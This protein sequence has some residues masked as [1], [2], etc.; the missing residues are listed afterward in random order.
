IEDVEPSMSFEKNLFKTG[1]AVAVTFRNVPTNT[2]AWVG[3]YKRGTVYPKDKSVKYFYTDGKDDNSRPGNGVGLIEGLPAGEY[4]MVL[5]GDGNYGKVLSPHIAFEVSTRAD[6]IPLTLDKNNYTVG[7]EIKVTYSAG[8]V[9]KADWIGIY[10]VDKEVGAA[11]GGQPSNV[12]KTIPTQSKAATLS[13]RDAKKMPAGTYYAVYLLDGAYE[14]ASQRVFF[15]IGEN[16][17]LQTTKLEYA[18]GEFVDFNV[19]GLEF[20][21]SWVVIEDEAS[22]KEV[23]RRYMDFR[24]SN[25]TFFKKFPIGKY[26]ATLQLPDNRIAAQSAPFTVTKGTGI[27]E[28]SVV[29]EIYPNPVK[30]TFSLPINGCQMLIAYTLD[31]K[32]VACVQ[33]QGKV[34]SLASLAS[35]HYFLKAKTKDAVYNYRIVKE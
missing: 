35:G 6:L 33:P 8:G 30:D 31:G 21:L 22:K 34:V 28:L 15:T 2:K 23:E 24:Q 25:K 1:E 9:F 14:E 12:W 26:S 20:P 19:S 10:S 11:P 16:L 29:K 3:V 27:S 17:K 4:Y 32:Q 18:E 7:E 5:F 13:F